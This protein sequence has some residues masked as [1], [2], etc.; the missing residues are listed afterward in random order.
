MLLRVGAITR[1]R[2][3]MRELGICPP[4]LLATDA[5]CRNEN[6]LETL[7]L[8]FNSIQLTPCLTH[9][10]CTVAPK[11]CEQSALWWRV[12]EE[13]RRAPKDSLITASMHTFN[14]IQR[15]WT[16]LL[17]QADGHAR[18]NPCLHAM[19]FRPDPVICNSATSI[20]HF[21]PFPQHAQ[22]STEWSDA[23]NIA[24]QCSTQ[25]LQSCL[26]SFGVQCILQCSSRKRG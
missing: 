4:L 3:L 1:P 22:P 18:E 8:N 14:L 12:K 25:C 23:K 17:P 5:T 16:N 9:G 26:L 19:H 11:M 13:T 20:S 2:I 21:T 7:L 15:R 24:R 10:P 6:R